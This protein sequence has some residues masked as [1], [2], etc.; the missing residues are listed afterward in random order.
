MMT[1]AHAD[2]AERYRCHTSGEV[3]TLIRGRI[4]PDRRSIPT[5]NYP[6]ANAVP[7]PFLPFPPLPPLPPF[8]PF[9]PFPPFQP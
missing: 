5:P 8:L 6:A 1:Q 7:K 9:Q 3:F 2:A 4:E